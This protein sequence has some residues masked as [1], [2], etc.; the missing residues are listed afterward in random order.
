MFYNTKP[1]ARKSRDFHLLVI[2][3]MF[4]YICFF[5]FAP[6]HLF[7]L[8]FCIPF[9]FSLLSLFLSFSCSSYFR[10][11]LIFSFARLPFT[12]SLFPTTFSLCHDLFITVAVFLSFLASPTLY[13]VFHVSSIPRKAHKDRSSVD[14][15]GVGPGCFPFR[16]YCC[17][18]LHGSLAIVNQ[19]KAHVVSKVSLLV[20]TNYMRV[21]IVP[22]RLD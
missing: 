16:T 8:F 15:E 1:N 14:R 20:I 11:F 2:Y 9:L 22:R 17:V 4:L 6:S 18:P 5:L 19:P 21:N 10:F 13:Q 3:S 7:R 12:V